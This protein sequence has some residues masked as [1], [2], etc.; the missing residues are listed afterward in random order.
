M[1]GAGAVAP[2]VFSKVKNPY[3]TET[4]VLIT[5]EYFAV[6]KRFARGL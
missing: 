2:E 4:T 3:L 6:G 1:A 5:R